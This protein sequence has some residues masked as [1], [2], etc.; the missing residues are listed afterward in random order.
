MSRPLRLFS[1]ARLMFRKH[2]KFE[3]VTNIRKSVS[4]IRKKY[5]TTHEILRWK[6]SHSH[7]RH[8]TIEFA[9]I[10]DS[11]HFT[12]SNEIFFPRSPIPRCSASACSTNRLGYRRMNNITRQLKWQLL[13]IPPYAIV[14]RGTTD[15]CRW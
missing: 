11:D 13:I 6:N 10:G 3:N 7:R 12:E 1:I 4:N 2:T 9:L 14:I 15:V 5:S 8:Q